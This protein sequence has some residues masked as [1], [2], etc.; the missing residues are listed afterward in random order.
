MADRL[1]TSQE[2]IADVLRQLFEVCAGKHP[3]PHRPQAPVGCYFRLRLFL[4][5][6]TAL[7]IRSFFSPHALAERRDDGTGHG[8]IG[9]PPELLEI[10]PRVGRV[11]GLHGDALRLAELA[12]GRPAA[13]SE[14]VQ[15]GELRH[16]IGQ[17]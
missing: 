1:G 17:S 11:D 2:L 10:L 15:L 8:L 12:A 9:R 13:L 3:G 7:M 6:F 14:R 5:A 4:A 16:S